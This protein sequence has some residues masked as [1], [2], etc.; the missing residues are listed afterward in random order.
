VAEELVGPGG[1]AELA[2][3][4]AEWPPTER[5]GAISPAVSRLRRKGGATPRIS[6]ARP[7]L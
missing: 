6:A 2:A 7:M 4:V 5:C 1:E 3:G